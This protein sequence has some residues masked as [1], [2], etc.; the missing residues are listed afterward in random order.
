MGLVKAQTAKR[1]RAP[2]GGVPHRRSPSDL[3][4]CPL[5]SLLPQP[6]SEQTVLTAGPISKAGQRATAEHRPGDK[7]Q[8]SETERLCSESAQP[9]WGP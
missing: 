4:T 8:S 5:W 2:G 6:S 7:S 9:Q 3:Q 1:R